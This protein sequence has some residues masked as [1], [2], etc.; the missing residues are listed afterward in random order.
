MLQ[1]GVDRLIIDFRYGWRNAKSSCPCHRG[2][3]GRDLEWRLRLKQDLWK[4]RRRFG[5]VGSITD[6][7]PQGAAMNVGSHSF[8]ASSYKQRGTSDPPR[9]Q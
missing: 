3:P 1:A 6:D 7:F 4:A 2:L 8:H 9:S 5:Q